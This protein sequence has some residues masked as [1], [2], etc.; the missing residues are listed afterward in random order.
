MVRRVIEHMGTGSGA[1]KIAAV[2]G[3][4]KA[5]GAVL[6]LRRWDLARGFVSS[7]P[8]PP[9][10]PHQKGGPV[11]LNVRRQ[12]FW[13]PAVRNA[14]LEHLRPHDLLDTAVAL[15][16]AADANPK[17][18]AVR[19]GHTSV[20]FTLDRYGHLLPG[21]EQ[22]LNGALDSLAERARQRLRSTDCADDTSEAR[23]K[24]ISFVH[25]G[26]SRRGRVSDA[27]ASETRT[28]LVGAAVSR[29]WALRDSEPT[30]SAV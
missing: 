17:E 13:T 8:R 11:Q 7:H 20:S 16:M 29:W 4:P 12:R 6:P 1:R 27:Q 2:N 26:G 22:R 10:P 25:A 14:G 21:S 28:N 30:T 9:P 15:W 5:G 23:E 3:Q 18:V 19:A 24:T